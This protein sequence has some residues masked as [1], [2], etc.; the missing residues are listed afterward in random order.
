M[1]LFK[2]GIADN[3]EFFFSEIKVQSGYQGL[4]KS[5]TALNMDIFVKRKYFVMIDS[6][7]LI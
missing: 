7:K 5:K 1:F 2:T 4:Y 6:Y 3:K